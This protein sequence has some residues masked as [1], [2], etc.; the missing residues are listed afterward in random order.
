MMTGS[1][2]SVMWMMWCRLGCLPINQNR[3]ISRG[4]YQLK[5]M[6]N[7][8]ES[9]ITS[10][11]TCSNVDFKGVNICGEARFCL[12]LFRIA[13]SHL[14]TVPEIFLKYMLIY[15]GL[16]T[17]N[18]TT[19]MGHNNATRPIIVGLIFWITWLSWNVWRVIWHETRISAMKLRIVHVQSTSVTVLGKSF[20]F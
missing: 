11:W 17:T 7:L 12:I 9:L 13:F 16:Y 18:M 3:S 15:V 5:L 8:L 6:Y 20:G 1:R 10:S 2:K 14:K 4:C 19:W